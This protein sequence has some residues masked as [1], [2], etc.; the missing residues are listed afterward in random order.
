MDN[1]A[2]DRTTGDWPM[3]AAQLPSGW[4]ELAVEMGVVYTKF[5]AHMG[6]KVT[7]A[8][9][10][11]QPIL[12][13]VATNSSLAVTV[14][15]AAAAGVIKMS[16]VG[17]HKRMRTIGPYL[18][19]LVTLMTDAEVVFGA[20]RWAGYDV[21]I[22][23][24]SS[25]SRPGAEGTTAR[26]HYALRLSTLRP[27]Q[28]EVTDDKVGETFRHFD[29]EAGQLWMGDRGYSNP[30]G[31]AAIVTADADVLVRYN[32]GSLPLY[33]I[34]GQL[35]DV[36]RMLA[37]LKRPGVAR[38]WYA[39]VHPQGGKVIV[40]RLC[41]LLLPPDEAEEARQR[42]RREQGPS[43]TAETL[44]AAQYVVVFTTVPSSRMTAALVMELYGL[45]WQ[46]ELHIKRD[47]SIAGLDRLPNFRSDTVYS[48]ICAKM[49]L[50]QI[51]RKLATP[52]VAIPPCGD[53]DWF[54]IRRAE[55]R[56]GRTHAVK[57]PGRRRTVASHDCPLAER[58]RGTHSGQCQ[59]VS[60]SLAG[61]P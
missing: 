9:H 49:L 2:K 1:T 56:K 33:G 29:A 11:L 60:R 41:A 58:P 37:R 16:A 39:E 18:A 47:K 30:P 15:M 61:I 32:R 24:G 7:K 3:I 27:V 35:L 52:N 43:V 42:A 44:V 21:V 13:Q 6:T 17:L 8:T 28:I 48:W 40:G 20:E 26:V 5:P 55:R 36:Q 34:N 25:V 54:G 51:A 31:I 4:E 19:R 59:S 50:T 38:E 12:Y 57:A 23:D 45:R 10:L 22:V 53:L 46:I 14:A